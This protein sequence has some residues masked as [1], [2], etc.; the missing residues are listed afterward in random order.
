MSLGNPNIFYFII[1]YNFE[2][3]FINPTATLLIFSKRILRIFSM[4][5]KNNNTIIIHISP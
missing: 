3:N 1:I 4:I 2:T 5:S